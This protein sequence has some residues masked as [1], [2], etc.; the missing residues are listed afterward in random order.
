MPR[1][2]PTGR[3]TAVFERM[4][5][6]G[7]PW[8]SEHSE[9]DQAS[10]SCQLALLEG[11]RYGRALELGCGAGFFTRRLAQMASRVLAIDVAPSA[12]SRAR[13]NVTDERID[14]RVVDAVE[15]DPRTEGPWDLIVMSETIYALASVHTFYDVAVLATSLCEATAE[16][17]RFL[18][19][20]TIWEKD[21]LARPSM[22]RTY[23]DLFVNVGYELETEKVLRGV[24]HGTELEAVITLFTKPG[25]GDA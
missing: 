23:R 19:A 25:R 6:Q 4:W 12:I 9:Y 1:E 14:F 22:I 5:K 18:M 21:L 10:Y 15:Y 7:D 11:R 24:K 8:E 17:G 16:G 13:V 2:H 3:A 20:N